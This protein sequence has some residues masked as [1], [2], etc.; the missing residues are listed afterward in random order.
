MTT[1]TNQGTTSVNALPSSSSS[2]NS[3]IFHQNS[4]TNEENF[5]DIV[6]DEVSI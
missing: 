1:S 6:E 5:D 3:A 4:S 2:Y